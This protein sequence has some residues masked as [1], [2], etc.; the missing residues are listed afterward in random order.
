MVNTLLLAAAFALA[1]AVV[2]IAV[3]A[4]VQ[5]RPV[6]DR[7]RLANQL[8]A[9]WW[10]GLGLATAIGAVQNLLVGR[11]YRDLDLFV[12]VTMVNL[13]LVCVALWGLLYYLL[14]LFT[15][16]RGLLGPLT[17]GYLA[18]YFWLQH[19]VYSAHPRAIEE[20]RWVVQVAY[21]H[22]IVGLAATIAVLLLVGPQFLGAAALG[23]LYF[24]VTEREQRFRIAV[25]SVSIFVWFGSTLA[26]GLAKV[27][28]N[29]VWQ[30][31]SRAIGLASALA[32]LVAYRPP[33]ALR[34]RLAPASGPASD[35]TDPTQRAVPAASPAPGRSTPTGTAS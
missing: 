20:H 22:P 14:Y 34:R 13:F 10:Y 26:V 3:G 11:G 32:I 28:D 25:V 23:T 29:D 30:L 8:F 16:R 21:E 31:T 19:L 2:Y 12:T 33:E 6:S 4:V 5:R 24:R 9:V 15:A 18:Y 1:S 7:H 17:V 27:G 35:V